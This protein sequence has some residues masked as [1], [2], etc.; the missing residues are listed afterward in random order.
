[1]SAAES[2][3]LRLRNVSANDD[4]GLRTVAQL[5]MELLGFGPMSGLGETFVREIC[6]RNHVR[7]DLLWL[8]VA[9]VD[10]KVAGLVAA[11]PYSST[12]HRHGLRHYFFSHGVANVCRRGRRAQEAG[13]LVS[14]TEGT[15]V[16]SR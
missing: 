6:Y 10:G 5:H 12:F 16:A 1:M 13:R 2:S 8:T 9:E 3:P 11:T 7:S 15:R 4:S 14:G